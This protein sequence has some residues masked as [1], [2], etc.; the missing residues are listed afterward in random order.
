M[1]GVW[2]NDDQVRTLSFESAAVVL[3]PVHYQPGQPH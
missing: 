3:H 2:V 1:P